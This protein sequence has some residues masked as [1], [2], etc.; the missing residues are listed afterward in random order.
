MLFTIIAGPHAG[1]A[2][3][4]VTSPGA[5]AHFLYTGNKSG[6]DVIEISGIIAGKTF[7]CTATRK[8]LDFFVITSSISGEQT[9]RI[10]NLS[11]IT[12]TVLS[13][14][15]PAVGVTAE[16]AVLSG[17]NTGKSMTS[18]TGPGGQVQFSYTSA[19]PGRDQIEIRGSVL[20]HSF[21][22]QTF[23][24]WTT[25]VRADVSIEQS[26]SPSTVLLGENLQFQVRVHNLGPSL[27]SGVLVSDQIPAPLQFISSAVSKGTVS[28]GRRFPG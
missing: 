25:V 15:L 23:Q 22:Q 18:L 17:I 7:K 10:N 24:T 5:G 6:L 3:T 12:A 2:Q 28:S 26:A 20:G 21:S 27:A 9:N 13:N 1:L 19:S 16:F 8:W 14:S 4:V 11:T